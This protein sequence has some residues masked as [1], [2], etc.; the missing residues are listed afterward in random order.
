MRG[1]KNG[2]VGVQGE[3]KRRAFPQE[4][5]REEV[6]NRLPLKQEVKKYFK[7]KLRIRGIC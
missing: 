2:Q 1:S 6:P 4:G 5:F 7:K 3:V